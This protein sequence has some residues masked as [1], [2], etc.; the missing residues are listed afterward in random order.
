M[1]RP[2]ALESAHRDAINLSWLVKLR[3]AA[4]IGQLVTIGVV[5]QG[6]GISLPL[7]PLLGLLGL[8]FATNV[9]A[10]GWTARGR[11]VAPWAVPALMIFDTL[12]FTA[13]LHL[14]GG[15]FNP[16]SFLY[17]VQIALAAVVLPARLTW[18]LVL[19]SLVG[20]G[21]LFLNYEELPIG[22]LS[23]GEHM[24]IHL[25]GMWVAFGVAA[26]FIVHFLL[27]ITRALR[28]RDAERDQAPRLV[29][30]SKLRR[31]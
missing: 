27:R 26:G 15:P 22:K 12:L 11:L 2:E 18:T 7:G 5:S 17:L 21:S 19:L 23:H 31:P 29:S 8:G 20:S 4:M 1:N 16:F 9:V 14:T 28:E 6:M 24:R 3:W 30:N 10:F 25:I 13:L